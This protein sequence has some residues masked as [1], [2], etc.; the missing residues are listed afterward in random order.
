MTTTSRP[1]S[2]FA[3]IMSTSTANIKLSI[4]LSDD[5]SEAHSDGGEAHCEGSESH[6]EGIPTYTCRNDDDDDD[7]KRHTLVTEASLRDFLER[8]RKGGTKAA[9]STEFK[10]GIA[11]M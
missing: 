9:F 3:R 10:H 8:E 11:T 1:S 2:F 4:M 5:G 7:A 6:S